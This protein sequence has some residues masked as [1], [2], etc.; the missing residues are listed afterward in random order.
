MPISQQDCARSSAAWACPIHRSARRADGHAAELA[1]RPE[2]RGRPDRRGRSA[3][4][5]TRQLP[6]TPPLAPVVAKV[7]LR[8]APRPACTAPRDWPRATISR[9]STSASSRNAGRHELA[10]N[11]DPIRVLNPIAAPLSV[12]RTSL[13]GSLVNVL[14]FNLNAQGHARARVRA[15]PCVPSRRVGA[16]ALTA[17]AGIAQPLRVAGLAYGSADQPQWSQARPCGRFLRREGRRRSAAGATRRALRAAEHASGLAS[18]PQCAASIVD[19]QCRRRRRRTASASG[20]RPTSCPAHPCCSRS[21]C[22]CALA[23]ELPAAKWPV[24]RQQ[25]VLRDLAVIV[26]EAV[27]HDALDRPSHGRSARWCA[28]RG[29][30]TS[31]SPTAAGSDMTAKRAQHGRAPGT[32]RRRRHPDRRAHRAGGGRVVDAL[33]STTRAPACAADRNPTERTMTIR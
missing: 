16:A 26:G 11:A 25:S 1:L 6:D 17:V 24:P 32:A 2:D 5:A 3:S 12:M 19:G 27:T 9:P 21:S 23:R 13:L 8:N 14:R 10:G 33:R 28:R 29:C 15:G 20:A 7:R 31:T 30:S 4:S 22:R 18:G